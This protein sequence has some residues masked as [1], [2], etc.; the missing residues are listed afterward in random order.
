MTS[1]LPIKYLIKTIWQILHEPL[2]G[3]VNI[4]QNIKLSTL[5][6][7]QINLVQDIWDCKTNDF[8]PFGGLITNGIF[9][10]H[11]HQIKDNFPRQWLRILINEDP[12]DGELDTIFLLQNDNILTDL[13]NATA[14]ELYTAILTKTNTEILCKAKWE[15]VFGDKNIWKTIHSRFIDN[16]DLNVII[17][18]VIAVRNNLYHWKIAPTPECLECSDVDSVL[19]AFFYCTKTNNLLNKLNGFLKNVLATTLN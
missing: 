10:R 12:Y 14:K 15:H 11:Y 17:H 13:Q 1:S 2:H 5:I 9:R 19:H 4:P 3:N 8:K 18:Q 6:G 16:W 7:F